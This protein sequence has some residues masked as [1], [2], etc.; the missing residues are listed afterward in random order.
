[1]IRS[2]AWR[3]AMPFKSAP[4]EAAVGVVFGTLSVR[5]AVLMTA[6]SGTPNACAA[7]WRTLV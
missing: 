5:V 6:L 1:M 4:E 2:Q 7:T 3:T